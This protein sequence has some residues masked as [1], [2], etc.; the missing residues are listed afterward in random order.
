M[1][2]ATSRVMK[3]SPMPRAR[4]NVSWPSRTFLSWPMMLDERGGVGRLAARHV[5]DAGRQAGGGEVRR[6]APRRRRRRAEPSSSR[7]PERQAD[8]DGHRLAV[9]QPVGIAGPGLQ[10][11]AE[12]VAQVEQHAVAGLGLVAGDDVGLALHADGDGVGQRRRV[13]REAPPASCCSS[14]SKKAA[15]PSRPYLAAS[16]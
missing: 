16:A 4:I 8:A 11:M 2:A 14:Q 15:S 7:Q 6:D 9:Q 5:G 12:G 10:R 13:L 3:A 1:S